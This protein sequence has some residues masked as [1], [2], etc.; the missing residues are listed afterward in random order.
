MILF[1]VAPQNA[2]EAGQ[3]EHSEIVGDKQH[4]NVTIPDSVGDSAHPS[5]EELL[6]F[7]PFEEEEEEDVEV[8]PPL[9]VPAGLLPVEEGDEESLP[10]PHALRAMG[11][12][13]QGRADYIKMRFF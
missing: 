1:A 6:G 9:P 3:N 13:L 8:I 4:Q 11:R 12:S 10:P 5:F 2:T 7:L